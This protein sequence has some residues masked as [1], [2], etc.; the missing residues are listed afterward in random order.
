MP[1]KLCPEV[2]VIRWA[3]MKWRHLLEGNKVPFEV[4][5]DHTN[6]EALQAH[7]V[8]HPTVA[9]SQQFAEAGKGSPQL[10]TSGCTT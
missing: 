4:W 3:L 5:T 8:C 9:I 7:S 2:F 10:A 1:V 6:L